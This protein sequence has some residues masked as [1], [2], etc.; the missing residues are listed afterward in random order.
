VLTLA[1]VA[2]AAWALLFLPRHSPEVPMLDYGMINKI[3]K[4]K[5]YAGEPERIHF[6]ELRVEFDGRNNPHTVEFHEG[7]WQC[8]CDYFHNHATCSHVMAL[9]RVLGPMSPHEA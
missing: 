6:Q 3:E 8:D 4:A 2:D 5:Q 9:D 1:H 7:H